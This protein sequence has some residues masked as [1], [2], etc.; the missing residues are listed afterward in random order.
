MIGLDETLVTVTGSVTFGPPISCDG[1]ATGSG[2]QLS[3]GFVELPW[4][5]NETDAT[6]P[7]AF[8]VNV[9][10]LAPKELGVKVTGTVMD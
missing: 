9:P 4:P 6:S 5:L 10:A 2:V 8:A 7:V 3:V 1:K